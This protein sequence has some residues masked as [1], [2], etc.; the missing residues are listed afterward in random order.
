MTIHF[1]SVGE[2]V[3]TNKPSMTAIMDLDLQIEGMIENSE[4]LWRC[5]VCGKTAKGKQQSKN[6]AEIHIEGLSHACH[7]C[8]KTLSTRQYLRQHISNYHSELFACN[9]CG[10][11]GMNR[12]SYDNHKHSYHK[13]LSIKQ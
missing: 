12:K 5:R 1:T 6:H 13:I 8:D 7:I 2:L 11:T 4:G 10:K 3:K 9:I